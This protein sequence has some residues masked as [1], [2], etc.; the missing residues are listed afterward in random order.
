[1][2]QKFFKISINRTNKFESGRQYFPP[3]VRFYLLISILLFSFSFTNLKAENPV[4]PTDAEI[5]A[6]AQKF[7]TILQMISKYYKDSVNIRK[8]SEVAFTAMLKDLDQFSD[9]FST[10][11]YKSINDNYKGSTLSTGITLISL[12]DT[13]TVT[14]VTKGSPADSLGIFSGDKILFI[15]GQNAI[16]MPGQEAVQK[17]NQN[18]DTAVTIIIKRG[19]SSSLQEFRIVKTEV[20]ITTISSFFIIP[21]TDIGYLKFVKFSSI[22]DKEFLETLDKLHDKGMKSVIIDLR[23][24]AGGYLEQVSLMC[25]EILPGND[26]I[27]YTQ[28]RHP[29][30]LQ[31]HI[32]KNG[33]KY[34]DLPVV[35]IMDGSSASASEILAGAVQDL[36]RGLVIGTIS[37]G[38]GSVQKLWEFK[39]GSAFRI[40]VAGYCTPSGRSIQKYT[41]KDQIDLSP[42][43]KLA[44]GGNSQ[45][46]IDE[47]N[48]KGGGKAQLPVFKTS[49]G[50]TVLGGGG[51]FPDYFVKDDTTTLLTQILRT[52]G[53]FLEFSYIYLAVQREEINKKY[54]KDFLRFF[55]EFTVDDKLMQDFIQYA[56]KK[57]VWN[58]KMYETDKNVIQGYVKA[59][60]SYALWGDPAYFLSLMPF[61]KQIQKAVEVMPE[62]KKFVGK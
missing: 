40:T 38:K 26:T 50:R 53:L 24:N 59:Y 43:A 33:Q 16:K 28:T 8:V 12:N 46:V 9:Y 31:T 11:Q 41:S 42:S 44:M 35:V 6:Q 22:A 48:K 34:E 39:D 51:I 32:S 1:M 27:T 18:P 45:K 52:N 17:I 3:T 58:E 61:D 30:F 29:D 21:K 13:I 19:Y 5:T 14:G 37:F 7:Q 15:N 2:N 54:G 55:N 25:D 62:A 36:D 23:G 56:K 4:N 47:I 10:E 20:L 60:I 49:K 57:K